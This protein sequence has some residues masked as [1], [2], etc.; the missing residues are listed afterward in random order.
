M[1]SASQSHLYFKSTSGKDWVRIVHL[2]IIFFVYISDV[3]SMLVKVYFIY[4][5]ANY[6]PYFF[7]FQARQWAIQAI[8]P[9]PAILRPVDTH[10]NQ[11]CTLLLQEVTPLSLG[12][13]PRRRVDTLPNLELTRP[14]QVPILASQVPI[15]ASQGRILVCL[16]VSHCIWWMISICVHCIALHHTLVYEVCIWNG[17]DYEGFILDI[18]SVDKATLF[19]GAFTEQWWIVMLTW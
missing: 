16:Q 14:S 17:Y 18:N 1:T 2:R 10:P 3:Q 9:S 11:G 5:F 4:S 12:C 7:Q 8:L 13:T 19:H 15:L 6:N